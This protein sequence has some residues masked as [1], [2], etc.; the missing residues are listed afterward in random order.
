MPLDNKTPEV[1]NNPMPME[2]ESANKEESDKKETVIAAHDEAEKDMER[3]PDLNT[4]PA[5]EADLDEGELA[6]FEDNDDGPA[7]PE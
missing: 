5:P 3:D 7:E 6:R 2:K 4:K 1:R